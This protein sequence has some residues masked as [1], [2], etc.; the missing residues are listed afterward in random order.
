MEVNIRLVPGMMKGDLSGFRKLVEYDEYGRLIAV[1]GPYE[2]EAGL[3]SISVSYSIPDSYKLP[4]Y[5]VTSNLA[6]VP[7]TS[8]VSSEIRVAEFVDGL[9]QADHG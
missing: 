6:V 8:T 9:G 5:A 7:G 4:A 1:R 2:L 3:S